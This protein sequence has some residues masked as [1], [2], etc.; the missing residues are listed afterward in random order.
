MNQHSVSIS[1]VS[2]ETHTDR[3]TRTST[4][5][6]TSSSSTSTS[7]T[8]SS[9]SPSAV[10]QVT[11]GNR[12][13]LLRRSSRSDP[14]RRLCLAL[15][16]P[17]APPHRSLGCLLHSSAHSERLCLGLMA[18][19]KALEQWCKMHCDGYRDVAIT[20]MTTS[21]RNGMAFCALIHKYR[22][23]LM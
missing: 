3:I 22:P 17:P 5:S 19:I 13:Q 14:E 1:G 7:T 9:S 6:T 16:F 18:A 4:S 2:A 23:D 21:F 20:N 15:V 12:T 11:G 8:S 10:T